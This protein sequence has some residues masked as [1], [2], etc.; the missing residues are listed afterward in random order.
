MD[1]GQVDL[2]VILGSNPVFTA[3][4]DF[5]FQERLGQGG[6][7]DLAHALSP[8]RRRST[9]TGTS[10]RRTPLESW[11]DA[12]AYDGTV[13]VMQPLIAPLYDGKTTQEVLAA[14][15]DAQNGKSAHDLVKDYWTRAQSGKVAGYAI[16]DATGQPFKSADSFWKHVLHDGWIP[17]T[18]GASGR[19]EAE[20]A[21]AAAAAAAGSLAVDATMP[22]PPQRR[23]ASRLG[24][25][26][27]SVRVSRSSSGPTPP[28]GTA[29]SPTTAGCRSCPSR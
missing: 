23:R 9:A 28:S 8:T 2:L 4:A 10:P 24:Q 7:V 17:G 6:A 3:P 13:T 19:R 20:A 1:A 25:P 5:K 21:G 12:R 22:A 29:A 26:E 16:T 15:I 27:R 11:G 18:G 14:F